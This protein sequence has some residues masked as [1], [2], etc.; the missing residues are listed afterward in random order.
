MPTICISCENSN[1]EIS[2][3]INFNKIFI[4][5]N[6]VMAKWAKQYGFKNNIPPIG[7]KRLKDLKIK[8]QKKGNFIELKLGKNNANKYIY[9]WGSQPTTNNLIINKAKDAYF[10]G[11]I[12][13]D[14]FA[15]L[16]KNGSIKCKIQNPQIYTESN[17]LYPPHIHYKV[18]NKKKNDFENAFYTK[19][20]LRDITTN[21]IIKIIKTNDMIILNA[22]SPVEFAKYRLPNSQCLYYKTK[23]NIKEF[24]NDILINY[25]KI[26]KALKNKTIKQSSIPIVVH[27]AHNKCSAAEQLANLLLKNN[28]LNIFHYP[29]GI[30]GYYKKKYNKTIY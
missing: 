18:V 24:M 13:N 5:K 6:N 17:K 25:P 28:Y 4:S 1:K 12:N 20:H 2:K 21:D 23:D 7:Y 22:L 3:L 15:K 27:C 26:Q 16:D 8:K 10:K 29:D 30:N 9:I 19:A 14:I 11:N